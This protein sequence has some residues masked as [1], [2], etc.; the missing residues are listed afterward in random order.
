MAK[1]P[2]KREGG[3]KDPLRRIEEI[4]VSLFGEIS[5]S[6]AEK[7]QRERQ[8]I[9]GNNRGNPDFEPQYTKYQ[10]DLPRRK[11]LIE[12]FK[13]KHAGEPQKPEEGP[14]EYRTMY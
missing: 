6:D 5:P 4:D 12:E 10:A 11:E 1:T 7:L 2:E 14:D 9:V 3:T 8:Q 13:R